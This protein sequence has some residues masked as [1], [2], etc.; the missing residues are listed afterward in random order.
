MASNGNVRRNLLIAG[1]VLSVVAGI[2]LTVAGVSVAMRL[3]LASVIGPGGVRLWQE[4]IY[5]S[6]FLPFLAYWPS[7]KWV[8]IAGCVGIVGLVAVAGGVSA[9]RRRSFGLSLAGAVCALPAW[10]LGGILAVI[11][12]AQGKG[13]FEAET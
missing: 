13:E 9:L 5:H 4:V 6:S 7:Y 1:G 3:M 12:V 2:S 10:F 11:F 8:I